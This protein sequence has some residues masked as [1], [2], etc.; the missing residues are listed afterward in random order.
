MD[1][2]DIPNPLTVN[3]EFYGLAPELGQTFIKDYSENEGITDQLVELGLVKKLALAT[4][5]LSKQGAVFDTWLNSMRARAYDEG[6]TANNVDASGAASPNLRAKLLEQDS[7]ALEIR[8]KFSGGSPEL[9]A[10][11]DRWFGKNSFEA[12]HEGW[13]AFDTGNPNNPYWEAESL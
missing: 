12:W 6:G 3:L 9:A 2:D 11:F 4:F 5:A 1:Q 8:E 13:R 7:L 10:S